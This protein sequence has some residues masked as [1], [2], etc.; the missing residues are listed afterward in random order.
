MTVPINVE[1]EALANKIT[2]FGK[3]HS[4][5]AQAEARAEAASVERTSLIAGITVALLLIGACVF[6]VFTIARPMR[7]LSASMEE[8]AGGN[9][10]VVLPGL[11]RKDEVGDVAGAVEKF[12]VVSEQKA[13]DEAEAKIKQ[14]QIA[15]QQRKADMVKLADGFEGAVGEI[16]ETVS[17]A[18]TELEASAVDADRDRGALAGTDHHGGGGLRG[19][20][21]QRAVGGVGDRGAVVLGQRDQPP[22]AG[23][24]A[25][26]QRGRRSGAQR[27]TIASANCQRRQRA[28]ATS[29]N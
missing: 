8:L 27:P 19:S 6:S 22:G 9:F 26:G 10:A 20:L 24:G 7:A 13:R 11:G 23:I 12:K 2:D 16:I 21:H 5:A 29:S 18:S 17:S 14:D 4:E 25:D 28:S 1:I 15:A 3:E